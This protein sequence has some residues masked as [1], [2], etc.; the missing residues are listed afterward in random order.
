VDHARETAEAVRACGG[1]EAFLKHLD[2]VA[3]IQAKPST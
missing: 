2:L 3:E 1:V